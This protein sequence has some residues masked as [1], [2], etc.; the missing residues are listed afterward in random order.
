MHETLAPA[1]GMFSS[2]MSGRGADSSVAVQSIS[3]TE[4]AVN[5]ARRLTQQNLVRARIAVATRRARVC[6]AA[7]SVLLLVAVSA[8]MLGGKP[9]PSAWHP[10][11]NKCTYLTRDASHRDEYGSEEDYT[12]ALVLGCVNCHTAPNDPA[13]RKIEAL[14][15]ER[16]QRPETNST[17]LDSDVLSLPWVNSAIVT[18]ASREHCEFAR[19]RCYG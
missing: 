11:R 19:A 17:R 14:D 8:A 9:A 18:I 6:A 1:I 16:L 15:V 10:D 13:R 7:A 2:A 12:R 5:A 3:A 4:L